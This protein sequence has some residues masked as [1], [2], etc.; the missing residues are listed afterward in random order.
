MKAFY[1][2]EGAAR[3]V[4]ARALSPANANLW[5]RSLRRYLPEVSIRQILDLG[6]GA[7]RFSTLLATTFGCPVVGVDPSAM[8][9]EQAKRQSAGPL[10][11]KVGAAE[12]LPIDDNHV[13]LVWMSQVVHHLEDPPRAFAEIQRVLRSGGCLAVRNV[14][15]DHRN[16]I[17]WLRCFPEVRQI[18]DARIRSQQE[19]VELICWADFQ[20]M[21]IQTVQQ[22]V[23]NSHLEYFEKIQQRAVSALMMISDEA[24]ERGLLRFKAWMTGQPSDQPVYEP[25]DLFVFQVDKS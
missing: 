10:T 22:L 8:M 24:F 12:Q 20:L 1:D 18:D 7:G 2:R 4:G 3:Y 6:C 23:A 25:M 19:L 13:D 11:W 5:M 16:Q 21:T 15:R 9:L 14:T 17:E